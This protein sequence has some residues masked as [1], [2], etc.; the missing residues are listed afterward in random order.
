METDC[1]VSVRPTTDEANRELV[2]FQSSDHPPFLS[3]F[4]QLGLMLTAAAAVTVVSS[5]LRIR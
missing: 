4:C 5:L 2:I 3:L 1:L